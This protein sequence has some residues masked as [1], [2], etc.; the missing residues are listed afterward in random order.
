M[1]TTT[2]RKFAVL[3]VEEST[4]SSRK[5]PEASPE[6]AKPRRFA[7]E[8]VEQTTKSSKDAAPPSSNGEHAKP[9]RF[10]PEP[11]ELPESKSKARRFAPQLVDESKKKSSDTE[12]KPK[13]RRFAPQLVE[14]SEEKSSDQDAKHKPRRFAPQLVDES[15][16]GDK[17][18][19]V[20]FSPEPIATT[21]SSNRKGKRADPASNAEAPK[22][23]PRKFTP[24]L[25]DTASRSRRAGDPNAPLS[26]DYRTEYGYHAHPHEHWRRVNGV[27]TPV[28]TSEQESD[29]DAMDVDSTSSASRPGSNR[30][31]MSPLDGSAP[32]RSSCLKPER[33]HSFRLPD[34]D[35]IESSESEEDSIVSSVPATPGHVGSPLTVSPSYELFKHATRRRESIDET[36]QHY[37]LDLERKKAQERLEEQALAAYPN[38]DFGYE[39]P[40]HYFNED[41]DSEV[42]EIEERPVTWDDNE[43]DMLEMARRESTAVMSWEKGELQ[44]HAEIRQQERNADASTA[45]KSGPSPFGKFD[46]VMKDAEL[47]AELKSMRERARPPML[48]ADLVFP[49]CASPDRAR[50]DVTQGSAILRDQMCYLTAAAD[51]ERQRTGEDEGLWRSRQ[52]EA[53]RV[54]TIK[55]VASTTSSSSKGLWGGFCVH[56]EKNGPGLWGSATPPKRQ[57]LE[58]PR[59]ELPNPFQLKTGAGAGTITPR[60][61]ISRDAS[62]TNLQQLNAILVTEH[63]IDTMMEDEFPDSAITQIYNYLSLGYPS[64]ARSF[65]EEL[66]KISRI[67]ISELRQDDTKARNAPRGYIRLGQDFEGGGGEGM[68]EESCMRW[69]ALK[70][71]VR[72]WA[73]QEKNWSPSEG[74][75]LANTWG[76]GARRGSW[77]I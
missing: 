44:R 26:Q 47:D 31:R 28:A 7:P 73:K 69:R 34:L 60:T 42:Y 10:A 9:R 49:R 52:P 23:P 1:S 58:T 35:T 71:Y 5:A 6:P 19:H 27:E 57:G 50:F 55:S 59:H 20:K 74:G 77:A 54:S 75:P 17:K 61:P 2:H 62:R 51:A 66:A 30:R 11:M 41:D 12:E 14:E 36:W 39:H 45:K 43:D 76:T 8:P 22:A 53:Q 33:G 24:I 40:H 48:G 63:Q 18:Q 13:P 70:R 56:D 72:E 32:P 65:D 46:T 38:P 64:L 68:V 29:P 4:K 21:Y 16:K 3:P 37:L 15:G 67:P 25:L